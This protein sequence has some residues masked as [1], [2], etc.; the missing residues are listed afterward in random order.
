MTMR[1][2]INAEIKESQ[3]KQQRMIK[4]SAT[5]LDG[6]EYVTVDVGEVDPFSAG[7]KSEDEEQNE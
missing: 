7:D 4:V 5:N 1:E 6:A 2:R 3:K